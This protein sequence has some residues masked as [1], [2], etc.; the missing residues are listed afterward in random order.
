MLCIQRGSWYPQ[1][2]AL[3]I[4][5]KHFIRP[6]LTP[7]LPTI[8]W[9]AIGQQAPKLLS[10]PSGQLPGADAAAITWAE[11]EWA[12]LGHLFCGSDT[13]MPYSQRNESS[14]SGW[15]KYGDGAP[16]GLGYW[17][18]TGWCKLGPQRCC[19]SSQTPIMPPARASRTWRHSPIA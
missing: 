10:T 7:P 13:T 12:A 16:G 2:C 1:P 17:V 15:I 14:W 9:S 6:S 4:S 11:P 18:T 19:S 5:P 8:D 3:P